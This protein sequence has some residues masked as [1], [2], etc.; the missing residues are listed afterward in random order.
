M[1]LF[2]D[3]H[4]DVTGITKVTYPD[5]IVQHLESSIGYTHEY[6]QGT[7]SRKRPQPLDE[8]DYERRSV[9]LDPAYGEG[10]FWGAG[11]ETPQRFKGALHDFAS[12]MGGVLQ[13]PSLDL[14]GNLVDIANL[15]A[16]NKLDRRDLDLG[17]AWAERGKTA[18]LLG[19]I[20]RTTMDVLKAA[21]KGRGRD[22]L[23]MFGLSHDGPRGVGFVDS[24]LAYRYGVRPLIHDV[25][26]A[27]KALTRKDISEWDVRVRGSAKR[28]SSKDEKVLQPNRMFRMRSTLALKARVKISCQHR[29]ITRQQDVM[30]SLGLDNPLATLYKTAPYSFVLDW[31]LPIGDWLQA[32]NSSKYYEGWQVTTS[33]I[34][35]EEA[36]VTGTSGLL[37]GN[38][39][40]GTCRGGGYRGFRL[41]RRALGGMPL[42]GLP[43]KDPR[44]LLHMADSLS[45]LASRLAHGEQRRFVRY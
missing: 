39:Y 6:R 18:Q 23:D 21:R 34:L 16:M 13:R 1:S 12:A 44:S 19:D 26:G 24:W 3:K 4:G 35:L 45:L 8:T 41:V 14:D 20:A 9:R 42:L 40:S 22:I 17:T 15:S 32:V 5:G 28:S 10:I 29:P 36:R 33:S 37:D 27:V 7:G 31:A 11:W 43:V 38:S 25:N 2:V 30:W